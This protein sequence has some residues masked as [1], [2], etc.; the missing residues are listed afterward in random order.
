MTYVML[1]WAY[2]Y[3]VCGRLYYGVS[4]LLSEN[5]VWLL[6]VDSGTDSECDALPVGEA[7]CRMIGCR[8]F[9]LIY[10]GAWRGISAGRGLYLAADFRVIQGD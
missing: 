3:R 5:I 9:V 4:P 7:T 10:V 8:V 2:S 1:E 6:A